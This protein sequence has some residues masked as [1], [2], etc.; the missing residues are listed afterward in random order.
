MVA[1]GFQYVVRNDATQGQFAWQTP[2]NAT[3]RTIRVSFQ[4]DR[5]SCM[6]KT[7][8]VAVSRRSR[9]RGCLSCS[10]KPQAATDPPWIERR[11]EGAWRAENWQKLQLA[12]EAR[13]PDWG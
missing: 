11:L 2:Q 12:M 10:W 3:S 13:V 9:E 8:Q 1:T 6:T 5:L 4:N 7:C